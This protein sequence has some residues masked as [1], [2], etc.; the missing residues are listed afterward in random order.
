MP[1]AI[2]THHQLLVLPAGLTLVLFASACFNVEAPQT[3]RCSAAE[4]ACPPGLICSAN[5]CVNKMAADA[6]SDLA[7][8]STSDAKSEGTTKD[9]AVI[10]AASAPDISKDVTPPPDLSTDTSPAPDAPMEASSPAPDSAPDVLTDTSTKV[11]S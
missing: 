8:D 6:A 2:K 5:L 10:D 3:Y 4:P 11:D 9:D 1:R 7:A